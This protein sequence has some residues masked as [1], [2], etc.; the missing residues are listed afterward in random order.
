MK[1]IRGAQ[2][3]SFVVLILVTLTACAATHRAPIVERTEHKIVSPPIDKSKIDLRQEHRGVS[4]S[5]EKIEAP[6]PAKAAIDELL[7][8]AERHILAADYD[9]A[10]QVINRALKI[11]PSEPM[12]WHKLAHL[13][14]VEGQ[15]A[16][17][18]LLALRSNALS[19]ERPGVRRANWQLIGSIEQATG[20]SSAAAAATRRASE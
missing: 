17:A 18:K 11:A 16:E 2:F 10:A 12:S 19:S 8:L 4:A 13:R 20:N 7:D 1:K 14:Y 9:S 6:A 15:Y 5:S 3:R